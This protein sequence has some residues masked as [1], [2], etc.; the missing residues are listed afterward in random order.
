MDFSLRFRDEK[1][2]DVEIERIEKA[3]AIAMK[4]HCGQYRESGEPYIVHPEFVAVELWNRYHDVD[5][6]IAG[7]LH[8][9]LEDCAEIAA[10]EIEQAFGSDVL[11]LVEALSKNL[12]S[13]TRVSEKQFHDPIEKLL[14]AGTQDVRAILIKLVDRE[15]NM[16]TLSHKSLSSQVR[17]SFETQCI[18]TPLSKLF[19][20]KEYIHEAQS[21]YDAYITAILQQKG[22]SLKDRV[23]SSNFSNLSSGLFSMIYRDADSVVWS[24]EDWNTYVELTETPSLRDKII[25]L[26]L[27]GNSTWFRGQFILKGP[28]SDNFSNCMI[29][30]YHSMTTFI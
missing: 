26:T 18:F 10:D 13:F 24:V 12:P 6:L 23:L 30:S 21:S 5:M 14:W 9:V 8:D 2:P 7:L 4:A 16:A 29:D 25:F 20:D 15:H 1:V 27:E 19:T 22:Q 11:F 28:L 3:H 17:I